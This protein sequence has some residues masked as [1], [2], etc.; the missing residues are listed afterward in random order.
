VGHL[1]LNLKLSPETIQEKALY[2][3]KPLSVYYDPD[4]ILWR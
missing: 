2:P 1:V 3:G 4:R